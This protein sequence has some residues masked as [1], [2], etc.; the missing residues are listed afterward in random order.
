MRKNVGQGLGALLGVALFAA[1]VY[2]L[3]QGLRHYSWAD[4]RHEL[5]RLSI[6]QIA[7]A[8]GLTAASYLLL[9]EYDAVGFRYIRRPLAYPRIALASFIGYSFSHNIGVAF[10]SGGGV[11]LRIYSAWGL[12]PIEIAKIVFMNGVTFALGYLFVGSFSVLIDPPS[13][14]PGLLPFASI[15][16]A[17]I[18]A[19]AI[20][21][22]YLVLCAT[23]R[24]PLRIRKQEFAM[25]SLRIA[26]LQIAIGSA[27]CM[28][29]ASV[30]YV[31]LPRGAHVSLLE[32]FGVYLIG[33]LVG[34]LSH[35]PGGV[36]VFEYTMLHFLGPHVPDVQIV[37]ALLAFRVVYFLLPFGVAIVLLAGHELVDR[38]DAMR[39]LAARF[40]DGVPG[41]LPSALAAATFMAGALL[42]LSNSRPPDPSRF[43][44][45]ARVVPL[46]L[47]DASHL[48][49]SVAGM[50]LLFAAQAMQ[51]RLAGGWRAGVACAVLASVACLAKGLFVEEAVASAVLAASL[52][53][54]RRHFWR[55]V[56]VLDERFPAQW[57]AAI[58]FALVASVGLG[59]IAFE[60]ARLSSD[61]AWSLGGDSHEARFHRGIVAAI[62]FAGAYAI[63][64]AARRPPVEP[65]SAGAAALERA[66]ALV[67][68]SSTP[69]AWRSLRDDASFL[70]A[71]DAMLGYAVVKGSW[72]ALGDP[73]GSRD[74]VR[75][76]AWR[77]REHV[78]RH[79]GRLAFFDVGPANAE[80]YVDVGL[81]LSMYGEA[82]RVRLDSRSFDGDAGDGRFEIVD[83]AGLGPRLAS[84]ESLDGRP[85]DRR[86]LRDGSVAILSRGDH[87]LAFAGLRTS[88]EREEIAVDFARRDPNAP[89]DA[90]DDLVR[91][92]ATAAR[93]RGFRWLDLGTVPAVERDTA[94]VD[95][96]WRRIG[97]EAFPLG[98]GLADRRACVQRF[99]PEWTPRYVALQIGI[100]LPSVLDDVAAAIVRE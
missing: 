43:E 94:I 7:A 21:I 33:Q 44:S 55:R 98:E 36:G 45:V 76:L 80:I 12:S 5:E 30:F 75:E 10:L 68:R 66:R 71:G 16:W 2:F 90:F 73:L 87:V 64:R 47:I 88:G 89:P 22:A 93:K 97:L 85:V 53:V 4:I 11:R 35:V 27:E 19:G 39:R 79:G 65:A 26:L 32:I 40:G 83:A 48:V 81:T 42:L 54:S 95:P 74:D 84:L 60:R 34:V 62:A 46:W 91:R 14:P 6:G 96:L 82:A 41:L 70:F 92:L 49:A 31:F 100:D 67:A 3:H 77:F 78:E 8:I 58:A 72:I 20:V 29:A 25:P 1:A 18:V 63:A 28:L 57:I 17:G 37:G 56:P 9:T 24:R 13:V 15:R 69:R 23:L 38:M 61:V 50:A 59:A 99:D 52:V 86:R 51:R